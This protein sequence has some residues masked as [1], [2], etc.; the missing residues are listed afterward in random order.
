MKSGTSYNKNQRDALFPYFI[1]VKNLTNIKLKNSASHWLLLYYII[2]I[3][4][5]AQS[6]EC[7]I[8]L[9]CP[10][11]RIKFHATR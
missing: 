10:S 3:Y 11:A 9:H 7:Q 5:D 1:S 8:V 6:P 2:R 4:H